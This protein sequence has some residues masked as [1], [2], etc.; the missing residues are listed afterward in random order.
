MAHDASPQESVAVVIAVRNGWPHLEEAVRS[1]LGQGPRVGQVVVVDD[2]SQDGGVEALAAI[3]DPRLAILG[4]PGRGVSAARN[5][6]AAA[7]T[8]SWLLFLDADD[9]LVDRAVD[10]LLGAARNGVAAVYGDYERIDE[11]GR[12]FGRRHLIR[13]AR[14]K[15]SGDI[16]DALL[17]GNLFVNGGVLICA[18]DAFDR[19]GGFDE[20]LA[21]CEDW[22]LWCRLAALGAIAYIPR[23]VL[24]Y[25]VHSTSVMMR[26]ARSYAEF[27]P[28]LQAIFADQ[29]IR[30]RFDAARLARLRRH[31]EVSLITYCAQ[32]ALRSG[33][34]IQ[35]SALA[36]GALQR[37][38]A[39]TPWVLSRLAGAWASL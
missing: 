23:H 16:L 36:L 38:P 37:F 13:N 11:D 6:G 27:L 32:Q 35:G 34:F 12:R 7:A 17:T 8:A 39:K 31:G 10:N 4:N 25:R 20:S 1:A 22:H 14:I 2:G 5:A 19:A 3:D 26:K 29:R 9:R 15:P 30:M 21:L 18:H 24:D 28:A 33:D